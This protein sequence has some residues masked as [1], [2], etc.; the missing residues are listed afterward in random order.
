MFRAIGA[1]AVLAIV[2]GCARDRTVPL[3]RNEAAVVLGTDASPSLKWSKFRGP[4]FDL[5][6]AL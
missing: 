5:L 4:D 6:H 3:T 1:I 2:A